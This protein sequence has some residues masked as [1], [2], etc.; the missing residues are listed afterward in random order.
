MILRSKYVEDPTIE[1]IN[2]LQ[3]FVKLQNEKGESST[4]I[5]PVISYKKASEIVTI[6][7]QHDKKIDASVGSTH[8]TVIEYDLTVKY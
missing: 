6:P 8:F 5:N 1:V 2:L 4:D 7:I 3:V